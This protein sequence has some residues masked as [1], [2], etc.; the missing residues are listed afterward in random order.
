MEQQLLTKKILHVNLD[1]TNGA[2]M[3]IVGDSG[4]EMV[5]EQNQDRIV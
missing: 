5:Q 3:E 2:V 1:H 4:Y